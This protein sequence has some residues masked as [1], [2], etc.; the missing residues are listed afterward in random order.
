VCNIYNTCEVKKSARD[1]IFG[2]RTETTNVVLDFV[3]PE[4]VMI[5]NTMNKSYAPKGKYDP[6]C[7]SSI[8]SS[9]STTTA[10]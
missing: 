10:I 1:K 4:D 9:F 5:I 6:P 2:K 7:N 8:P 3:D